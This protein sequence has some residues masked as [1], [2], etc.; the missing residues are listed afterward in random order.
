MHTHEAVLITWTSEL[1]IISETLLLCNIK[2]IFCNDK[3]KK[4]DN[5]IFVKKQKTKTKQLTL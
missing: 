2:M 4:D 3:L 5:K 1:K